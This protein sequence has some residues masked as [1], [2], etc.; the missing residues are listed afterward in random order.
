MGGGGGRGADAASIREMQPRRA[1]KMVDFIENRTKTWP[2][3]PTSK[4]FN[5]RFNHTETQSLS[6]VERSGDEGGGNVSS[7]R[8]SRLLHLA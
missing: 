8:R 5:Y 4:L 6:T 7:W 2:A 1:E 3:N